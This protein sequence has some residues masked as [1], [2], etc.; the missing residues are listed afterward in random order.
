M[1]AI[2]HILIIGI[3]AFGAAKLWGYL[4][5]AE[6][7]RVKSVEIRGVF[8]LGDREVE[9]L[10]GLERGDNL[11]G[12]K[13][14][15]AESRLLAEPW[16]RKVRVQRLVP[17]RVVINVRERRP[18]AL[19]AGNGLYCLDEEGLLLP[20]RDK[21]R[22]IGLPVIRGL[23][24]DGEH[25]GKRV[26]SY[27]LANLLKHVDGEHAPFGLRDFSEIRVGESGYELVT[28][29]ATLL[30]IGYE[31]EGSLCLL[32]RALDDASRRGISY[33]SADA[34]VDGQVILN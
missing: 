27:P 28:L 21:A 4:R 16:V 6:H 1:R 29:D 31:L 22:R 34:R 33:R 18:V 13:P 11:F 24:V 15:Q 8:F 14:R 20:L 17:D 30:H 25:V 12:F 26:D 7:F 9:K 19:V 32:R 10:V 3:V 2:K 23:A 5:G